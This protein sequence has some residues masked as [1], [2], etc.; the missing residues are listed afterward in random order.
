MQIYLRAHA[1]LRDDMADW[2]AAVA[3]LLDASPDAPRQL[4]LAFAEPDSDSPADAEGGSCIAPHL[5]QRF[6]VRCDAVRAL[7]PYSSYPN[8]HNTIPQCCTAA[9]AG[10]DTQGPGRLPRQTQSGGLHARPDQL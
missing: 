3:A 9:A 7:S 8:H 6:L 5:A 4:L 10:C 1:S 2:A